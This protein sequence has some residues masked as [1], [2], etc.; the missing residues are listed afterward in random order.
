MT[1]HDWVG[2]NWSEERPRWSC[3]K[4]GLISYEKSPSPWLETRPF[5]VDET[6]E[7]RVVRHVQES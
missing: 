1:G 6:C 3:S 4:C 5:N 7:D 2:E